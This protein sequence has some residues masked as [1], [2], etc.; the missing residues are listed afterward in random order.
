MKSANLCQILNMFH[1]DRQGYKD[2]LFGDHCRGTK[3][4]QMTKKASKINFELV[5]ECKSIS[6]IF[7]KA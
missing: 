5:E 3:V 2:K 7:K 6:L 1:K 4:P